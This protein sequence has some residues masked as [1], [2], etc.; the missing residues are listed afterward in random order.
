LLVPATPLSVVLIL[1]AIALLAPAYFVKIFLK[2]GGEEETLWA[3]VAGCVSS[4]MIALGS[5]ALAWG[6]GNGLRLFTSGNLALSWEAGNGSQHF[7]LPEIIGIIIIFGL[8]T[9]VFVLGSFID[10]LEFALKDERDKNR[11]RITG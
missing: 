9:L 1:A 10:A 5:F 8:H 11:K 4:A 6:S 7:T 2:S 3:R